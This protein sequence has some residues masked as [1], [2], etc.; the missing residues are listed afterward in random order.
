[1]VVA[2][3]GCTHSPLEG[4]LDHPEGRFEEPQDADDILVMV[5][6]NYK[7]SADIG[8]SR[9]LTARRLSVLDPGAGPNFIH[10][11]ELPYGFESLIKS[12][13]IPAI[14]DANRNSLRT[15]GI[16]QISWRWSTTVVTLFWFMKR[17]PRTMTY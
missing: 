9:S 11:A 13:P 10:K 3:K 14:S 5:T 7:V 17:P 8:I 15:I 1:M 2:A 16:I 6:R 4:I 12:G